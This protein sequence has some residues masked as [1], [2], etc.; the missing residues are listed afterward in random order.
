MNKIMDTYEKKYKEALERA[1][2]VHTTNVAENKKITE[3][4][5]PEFKESEDERIRKELI[6]EVKDQIDRIPAPD[7]MDEEDDKA[8]KQ[9]NKWLA[10]LEKQGEQKPL[11]D[12]DAEIVEAVKDVS[13][14]DLVEPKSL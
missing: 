13:I 5:F 7:C 14:L 8:L 10:W 12:T 6:A 9:L 2:Q 1:R 11:N 3:Y 4:I